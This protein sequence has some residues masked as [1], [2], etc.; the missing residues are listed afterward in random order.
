MFG[1]KLTILWT[2]ILVIY[3]FV[4]QALI[5][6]ESVSTKLDIALNNKYPKYVWIF[7]VMVFI[8]VVGVIYSVVWFLFLR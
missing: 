4:V 1:V 6:G 8:E 3:R 5:S 2:V 7:A